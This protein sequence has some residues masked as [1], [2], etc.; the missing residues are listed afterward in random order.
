MERNPSPNS[1]FGAGLEEQKIDRKAALPAG[2]VGHPD[3]G[4]DDL[5]VGQEVGD[6]FPGFLEIDGD[7]PFVY[8]DLGGGEPN[9]GTDAWMG[10]QKIRVLAFPKVIKH[11]LKRFPVFLG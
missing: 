7:H 6:L 9:P 11:L 8:A 1:E 4:G 5:G 2:K 3:G 10:F